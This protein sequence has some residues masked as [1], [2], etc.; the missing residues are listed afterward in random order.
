MNSG[1]SGHVGGG[2]GRGAGIENF[3]SH[4]AVGLVARRIDATSR[5]GSSASASR[6]AGE[7]EREREGEGVEKTTTTS[8]IWTTTEIQLLMRELSSGEV[9]LEQI[10]R[11]VANVGGTRKMRTYYT[12]IPTTILD[13]T[14]SYKY[15]NADAPRLKEI[16][17]RLDMIVRAEEAD[18]VSFHF[19]F[20]D[21]RFVEDSSDFMDDYCL[22]ADCD[23]IAGRSR[24]VEFG[25]YWEYIGAKG[26]MRALLIF[27]H[28]SRV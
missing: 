2:G 27:L 25:L 15:G 9:D 7:K 21:C 17:K 23:G 14:L 10:E 18:E 8:V 3:R 1:G 16:R 6:G 19:S 4:L 12:E 5:F 24:R 11:E 20:S 22:R 28:L 13:P 26:A